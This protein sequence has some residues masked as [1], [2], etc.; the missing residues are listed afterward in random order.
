MSIWTEISKPKVVLPS[1]ATSLEVLVNSGL[2]YATVYAD[3]PWKYDNTAARGAAENHYQTLSLEELVQLP[4][5]E[6]CHDRAHLHLW[7]TNGFLREAFQLIEAWG[8]EY[9]SCFLWV[10]PQLGMGNYWRVSHEFLLLGVRGQ[11]PFR[12]KTQRSWQEYPRTRHS[13][14]PGCMRSIIEKVSPGPYLELFGRS[15]IPNG[16]WTVFGNEVERML[17]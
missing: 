7:T 13:K 6:L 12:E 8:F 15:E 17:F 16:L 3:P 1:I 5:S 11:L 10:K 14:K 4:I 2:K 9:K